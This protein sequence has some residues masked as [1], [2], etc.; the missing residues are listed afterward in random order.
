MPHLKRIITLAAIAAATAAAAPGMAEARPID[1]VGGAVKPT[2]ADLT[3][4][5][6]AATRPSA[7]LDR[8]ALIHVHTIPSTRPVASATGDPEPFQFG[9]AAIGAGAI[10]GIVLL[11][12]AGAITGRRR[13]HLPH[14]Q[15]QRLVR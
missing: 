3:A 8:F 4:A 14:P 10:A 7:S 2:N 13:V 11:G 6:Y 9:D 12:T 5:E 1:P 15:P